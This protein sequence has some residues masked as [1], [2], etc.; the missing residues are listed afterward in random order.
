MTALDDLS[1]DEL[2]AALTRR[3]ENETGR[4]AY[5]EHGGRYFF[6]QGIR[7]G[8]GLPFTMQERT[9]GDDQPIDRTYPFPPKPLPEKPVLPVNPLADSASLVK[10]S[11]GQ[12]KALE[13]IESGQVSARAG[14][15]GARYYCIPRDSS[16]APQQR[17]FD[18]LAELGLIHI[19]HR[20]HQ[21]GGWVTELTQRGNANLA[22]AP[23]PS[24]AKALTK[25]QHRALYFV[26]QDW[27]VEDQW[28]YIYT[29]GNHQVFSGLPLRPT[30]E[31][32]REVGLIT[33]DPSDTV[34]TGTGT[35]PRL[36]L[37]DAG[38]KIL[39]EKGPYRG[40]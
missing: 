20:T 39:D 17:T 31:R 8:R 27:L 28:G 40:N 38:K 14:L 7:A 33:S 21:Y 2:Y 36:R 29:H 34:N 9:D 6:E 18:A 5:K 13:F 1:I 11:D 23:K 25:S 19:S 22:A 37:T 4:P 16:R 30:F 24:A 3:I 10:L 35:L 26:G 12:R 15:D 32:L